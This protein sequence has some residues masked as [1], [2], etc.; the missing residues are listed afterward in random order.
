MCSLWKAIISLLAL[1]ASTLY[2]YKLCMHYLPFHL[3][4]TTVCK[5]ILPK[6]HLPEMPYPSLGSL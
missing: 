4:Y 1:L 5:Y 3:L 6:V 2:A